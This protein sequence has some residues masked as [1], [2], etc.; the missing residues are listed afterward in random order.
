MKGKKPVLTVDEMVKF[1]LFGS[2]MFVFKTVEGLPNVHPLA[3]FITVFTVVYRAKALWIIL[4][5]DFMVGLL[6]AGFGVWWY[7]YLYIWPLLWAVVMLLP[8]NMSI[9][10]S[11]AVYTAVCTLHGLLYGTLYSPYQAL[12]F[13]LNF[14]GMLT[15]IAAGFPYDVIHAVS[16]LFMGLLVLPLTKLLK[17][18]DAH[19][20]EE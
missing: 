12:V 3:M 11:V 1:A 8:K 15:W 18:L 17:R 2:M 10:K 16:N 13:G 9:R 7:P 14:Q 6:W 5:F 19:G 20:Y 4:I